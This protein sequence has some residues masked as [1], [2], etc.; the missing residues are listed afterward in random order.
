MPD[1]F[2]ADPA[3]GHTAIPALTAEESTEEL[4]KAIHDS[5]AVLAQ[6]STIFPLTLFPDTLSIDRAKVNITKRTFFRVAETATF[7]IEDILSASST[8]GPFFGGV[9]IISRVMNQEQETHIGPFWRD[10]AERMKRILHGYVIAKQRGI[11][12]SQVSTKEL[13]DMLDELGQD[14]RS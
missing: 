4:R 8:V 6:A 1:S 9:T 10:D 5:E 11:D 7:R 14:K 2:I 3:T 12:T 13:A